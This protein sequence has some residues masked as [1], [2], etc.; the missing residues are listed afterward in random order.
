MTHAERTPGHFAYD[1][2]RTGTE[3]FGQTVAQKFLAKCDCPIA[4]LDGTKLA[5]CSPFV[6]H[7]F[8]KS[9]C[10][11]PTG[12]P[13]SRQ[14]CEHAMYGILEPVWW[15]SRALGIRSQRSS[16][17]QNFARHRIA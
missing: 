5:Q 3:F 14:R 16:W 4:E 10:A 13:A 1:C 8:K 11:E 15:G 17:R 7:A 2:E 12:T 6:I 9:L